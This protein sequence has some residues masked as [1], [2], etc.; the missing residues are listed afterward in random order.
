[1]P[2]GIAA[3]LLA[4]VVAAATGRAGTA[5]PKEL[6]YHDVVVAEFHTKSTRVTDAAGGNPREVNVTETTTKWFAESDSATLLTR[7]GA[8]V[9][10]AASVKGTVTDYDVKRTYSVRDLLPADQRRR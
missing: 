10:L 3:L 7:D 2:V 6:W 5:A 9:S 4:G 8:D 1:L